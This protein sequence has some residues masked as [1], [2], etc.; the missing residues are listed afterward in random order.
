MA[1]LQA[2]REAAR[3]TDEAL[4]SRDADKDR[5]LSLYRFGFELDERIEDRL[6]ELKRAFADPLAALSGLAEVV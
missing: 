2:V 4:P 1:T 6:S 5:I 3:R